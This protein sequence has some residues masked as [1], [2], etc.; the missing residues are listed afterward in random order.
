ML[1]ISFLNLADGMADAGDV[2]QALLFLG[3]AK[4]AL[5][6]QE[7]AAGDE[8]G[9][10]THSYQVIDTKRARFL[11]ALGDHTTAAS[12]I[13]EVVEVERERA[14]PRKAL[15]S[16]LI[17]A[18]QFAGI[19]YCTIGRHDDGMHAAAEGAHAEARSGSVVRACSYD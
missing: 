11:F 18:L 10:H 19:A 17:K 1:Y 6:K 4:D 14:K 2:E 8:V 13:E 9:T 3:E 5:M 7:A 16:S 12:L 15:V